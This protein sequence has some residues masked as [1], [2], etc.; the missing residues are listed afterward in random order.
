MHNGQR[1][2]TKTNV[3]GLCLCLE[4]EQAGQTTAIQTTL[5]QTTAMPIMEVLRL[6]FTGLPLFLFTG[7]SSCGL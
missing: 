2:R 5:I 1:P 7:Q 4:K 6:R 3:R